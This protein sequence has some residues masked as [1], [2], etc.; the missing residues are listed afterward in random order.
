MFACPNCGGNLKFDISAQKLSC[1][2][3]Q[4]LVDPYAF[5]SQEKGAIEQTVFDAT[6]FTCPQCGGEILSTDTSLAEFCSFCG[7][8][9]IFHSRIQKEKRPAYIIPFK[10]TKEDCKKAYSSFM[11]M[12]REAQT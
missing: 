5:D 2:N 8:S 12:A 11:K 1:E 7:A 6:I 10:K 3:C 9:T 4:T